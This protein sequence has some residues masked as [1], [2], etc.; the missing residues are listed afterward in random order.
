MPP[1]PV[2][3][4]MVSSEVESLARTGGLGDAVEALSRSL[5][6]LGAD[7]LIVTPKYAVT[8][9]PAGSGRWPAPVVA[10]LGLGHAR[11][12]GVLE[13]RLAGPSAP[14]VALLTEGQ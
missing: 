6:S 9:V 5:G 2:R 4:L 7:V 11:T 10:P 13:A 14:R 12:L 8:R 1:G 3:V